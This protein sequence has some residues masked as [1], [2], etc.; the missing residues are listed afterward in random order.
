MAPLAEQ[1]EITRFQFSPVKYR[2][3]IGLPAVMLITPVLNAIELKVF[4]RSTLRADPAK[5]I[6]QILY[7]SIGP[8]TKSVHNSKSRAFP[9]STGHL[10][11]RVLGTLL[12]QPLRNQDCQVTTGLGKVRTFQ[13]SQRYPGFPDPLLDTELVGLA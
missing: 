3:A 5:G 6:P 11:V 8:N 1:S 4:C 13:H 12:Y 7:N 10:R 2:S 9:F